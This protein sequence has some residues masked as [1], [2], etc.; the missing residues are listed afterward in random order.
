[1]FD[2]AECFKVKFMQA[3]MPLY[4]WVEFTCPWLAV[5]TQIEVTFTCPGPDL[6]YFPACTSTGNTSTQIWNVDTK[7]G[8]VTTYGISPSDG[9]LFL[10]GIGQIF[11]GVPY[12]IAC[13]VPSCMVNIFELLFLFTGY[14]G[15]SHNF[16]PGSGHLD[17]HTGMVSDYSTTCS[18]S[19]TNVT[20]TQTNPPGDTGCPGYI[21]DF[22]WS[23]TLSDPNTIADLAANVD[24]L[25]SYG[26]S[27]WS[28]IGWMCIGEV[29]Y[30][31]GGSPQLAV[32]GPYS[33]S[34][35]ASI[36]GLSMGCWM[37]DCAHSIMT[38]DPWHLMPVYP[39]SGCEPYDGSSIPTISKLASQ[40]AIGGNYTFTTD[41]S[42]WNG[43]PISSSTASGTGVYSSPVETDPPT[44]I[45]GSGTGVN[46]EVIFACGIAICGVG[47]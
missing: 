38:F 43:V 16:G 18:V 5:Y 26:Y 14:G 24:T 30:D 10:N 36:L 12:C 20:V 40:I 42:D 32:S 15:G 1:M 21:G 8:A 25:M 23:I 41:T 13:G 6:P 45:D 33:A 39:N 44:G 17:P 29:S 3:D 22:T 46:T 9:D 7:T 2:N 35:M 11:D 31:S 37:F 19:A 4:G 28:S 34:A 47:P 27:N